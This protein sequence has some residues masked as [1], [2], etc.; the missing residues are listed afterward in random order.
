MLLYLFT[1]LI[2]LTPTIE[3]LAEP[4]KICGNDDCS[5]KLFTAV[6]TRDYPP[7]HEEFIN[8]KI[9]DTITVYA[10]KFS[11]RPDIAEG[12]NGEGIRGKFYITYV[13]RE[14]Y[15]FFLSHVVKNNVEMSEVAQSSIPGV[16]KLVKKHPANPY[17]WRDYNVRAAE[18]NEKVEVEMAPDPNEKK[19]HHHHHG[20]DHHHHHGHDHSHDGHDHT[21]DHKELPKTEEHHLWLIH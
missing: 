17:L 19:S 12:V 7:N 16:P 8:V 18:L 15:F 13:E 2:A 14:A 3:G 9:N 4:T 21:H 20:H 1:I 5:A 6:A 10:I 11:N